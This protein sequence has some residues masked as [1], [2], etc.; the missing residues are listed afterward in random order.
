MKKKL[1]LASILMSLLIA[2]TSFLT[3]SCSSDG[4]NEWSESEAFDLMG[5]DTS[6][7]TVY[8][9][10]NKIPYAPVDTDMLPEAIR[11]TDGSFTY[12]IC[13]GNYEGKVIYNTQTLYHSDSYGTYYSE[14][15]IM[16]IW[17]ETDARFEF[18]KKV[19]DWTCV[20]YNPQPQNPLPQK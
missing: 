5:G 13:K 2:G 14:E 17:T 20:Y 15:G 8:F 18:H 19:T 11:P 1:F 3:A 16:M 9:H 10:G 6:D 7:G 4:E 12:M